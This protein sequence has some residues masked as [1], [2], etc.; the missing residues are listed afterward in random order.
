MKKVRAFPPQRISVRPS[1]APISGFHSTNKAKSLKSMHPESGFQRRKR[2]KRLKLG[3]HT[4]P[5]SEFIGSMASHEDRINLHRA[6]EMAKNTG[7]KFSTHEVP[8]P[9]SLMA[10]YACSEYLKSF[11]GE[12]EV[13]IIVSRMLPPA[14]RLASLFHMN[15]R[16]WH[17]DVAV[18]D[19]PMIIMDTNCPILL[20]GY[21]EYQAIL[22]VVDHHQRT[23]S[24]LKSLFTIANAS[25]I[26]T[27][28][29]LASAIPRRFIEEHRHVATALAIGISGDSER[30]LKTSEQTL[31]IFRELQR[32]SGIRKERID[33]IAFPPNDPQTTNELLNE[34]REIRNE[35]HS[36]F[37]LSVAK[38]KIMPP[39]IAATLLRDMGVNIAGVLVPF[40]EGIHQL[41]IRIRLSNVTE[42]GID[43]NR[44]AKE[45]S[46]L[47]G[48]SGEK[49]GGGHK[50]MAGARLPGSY[51]ELA[52]LIM[53]S[54]K[55][56]VDRIIGSG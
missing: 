25:A 17:S 13:D 20:N 35:L 34:L 51:E 43:A 27:C 29:L 4:T 54:F 44:I 50:H 47:C 11:G 46:R 14:Q 28:E 55:R 12:R 24:E 2:G 3:I 21:M 7:T 19:R 1:N 8:D 45:L 40:S 22:L 36:G 49:S 10:I 39:A 42:E 33:E 53:E 18:D 5:K 37:V 38:S 41:S 48:L 26:S 15:T 6:M 56:E 52:E 32:I 31:E 9:D 16:T 30:L 23:E